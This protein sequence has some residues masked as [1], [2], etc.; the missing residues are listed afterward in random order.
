MLQLAGGQIIPVDKVRGERDG[1]KSVMKFIEK[2]M[3]G[4]EGAV[5]ALTHT[6]APDRARVLQELI[7]ER[8]NLEPQF[9]V[10]ASPALGTHAG[11]GAVGVA[12]LPF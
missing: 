4:Y 11:P 10:N 7:R 8:F 2:T 9:V 1:M 12:V 5:I 6:N 3:S